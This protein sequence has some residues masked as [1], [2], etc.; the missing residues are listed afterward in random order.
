M[1]AKYEIAGIKVALNY[2]YDEYL[3]NNIESY[4][5]GDFEPVDHEIKVHLLEHIDEPTLQ[6]FSQKNPYIIKN[7]HETIMYAKNSKHE[8]K[9][10]FIIKDDYKTVDIYINTKLNPNASEM[11]YV[12]LSVNFIE[13]AMRHGFL[14]FHASAILYEGGSIL[15]SAPSQTG[16][17][18][19]AKYWKQAFPGVEF[20]N[21]DKP[22]LRIEDGE[23]MVYGSPFS[24]KSSVN[25][26]TQ[27]PLTAIVFI[28]QGLSNDM[29]R[30]QGDEALKELMRNMLRPDDEKL[31]DDMILII[32]AIMDDIPLYTLE[33]TH[34]VDAAKR[35]HDIIFGGHL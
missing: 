13:I 3:T 14:P 27:A 34:S 1:T 23:I 5:I 16:K 7:D 15:F 29:R 21:D 24:G 19:H 33:A 17:S 26:N 9:E 10:L 18:T 22:L 8:V 25:L 12:L 11:E 32:N 31:W 30:I 35:A 6:S 2:H 28:K 4:R 20:L